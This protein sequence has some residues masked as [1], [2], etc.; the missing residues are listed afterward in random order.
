MTEF[1]SERTGFCQ[2]NVY[3]TYVHGFFD[4]KEV[5][6]AVTGFEDTMDYEAFRETQYDLLAK[7]LRESLDMDYIYEIMGIKR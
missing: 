7:V 6:E 1:T 5:L 4:R 3:G 2:G